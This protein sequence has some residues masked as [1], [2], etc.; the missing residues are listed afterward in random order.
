MT[1][2]PSL[3]GQSYTILIPPG[4]IQGRI[5]TSVNQFGQPVPNRTLWVTPLVYNNTNGHFHNTS[6]PTSQ[7]SASAGGGFSSL[8]AFV[9]TGANA[10]AIVWIKGGSIGQAEYLTACW[11]FCG[12]G[13]HAVG[14]SG[15]YWVEEKPQWIHT[16]G[17]TTNHGG[18]EFNHW[19]QS[20]PAYGIWY[21]A[22]EYLSR[23]PAQGKIAVND[24][25]LPF[26]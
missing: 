13:D 22:V 10:T 14:Y 6:R 8:G 12:S 20:T 5:V 17:N 16:G 18:N 4:T 1:T 23:Y 2:A 9:T 24:M 21:T 7:V 11:D 3:P 15:I 25:S 19:M 26:G